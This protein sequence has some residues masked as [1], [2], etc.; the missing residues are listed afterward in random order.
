MEQSLKITNK[1]KSIVKKEKWIIEGNYKSS[2][3]LRMP[4]ADLIII[5]DIS[6]VICVARALKRSFEK[7]ETCDK[8][9]G[10]FE[11][12]DFNFA[13][14][15]LSFRKKMLPKIQNEVN[16][17]APNTKVIHIKTKRRADGFF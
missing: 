4:Y 17:L 11:K 16:N 13:R 14:Y 12:F 10:C 3:G 15:I 9:K 7:T 8:A 1:I 2:F 5:L 6:P